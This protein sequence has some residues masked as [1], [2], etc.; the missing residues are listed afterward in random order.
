MI[1]PFNQSTPIRQARG[2]STPTPPPDVFLAMAAAQM[3]SMGRLFEPEPEDG[4]SEFK[5][6]IDRRI[7]DAP[8]DIS[9]SPL[10][11]DKGTSAKDEM[12]PSKMQTQKQK[13]PVEAIYNDSG[14]IVDIDTKPRGKAK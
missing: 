11:V 12:T 9:R 4:S 8:D 3:H 10:E 2:Q 7:G 6:S 1:V 14:Q 13:P 5:K